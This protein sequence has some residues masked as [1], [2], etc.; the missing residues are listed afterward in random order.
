[1]LTLLRPER[2]QQDAKQQQGQHS[3][4]YDPFEFCEAKNKHSTAKCI[5]IFRKIAIA[6]S[7]AKHSWEC[8]DTCC[9]VGMT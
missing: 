4:Q 7:K 8:V 9:A 6:S 5:D 2:Q 1:M 3:L